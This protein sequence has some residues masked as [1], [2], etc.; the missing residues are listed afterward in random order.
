MRFS[1]SASGGTWSK[2]YYDP[3]GNQ[4]SPNFGSELFQFHSQQYDSESNL[5]YMRA[6]YYDPELGRFISRDPVKGNIIAPQSLHPY[7]YA[8]NNPINMSDTSGEIIPE[9][10][11]LASGLFLAGL[12]VGG[13]AGGAYNYYQSNCDRTL[14]GYGQSAV[15]GM[16]IAVESKPGQVALGA[17]FLSA[18]FV[19]P[20]TN[21][22]QKYHGND[23]RNPATTTGYS[24]QERSAGSIMKYGESIKP[25]TRY[26][27]LFCK[28]TT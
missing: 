12:E 21:A 5:Y 13:A 3:F 15:V 18:A 4:R 16:Q 11:F 28:R 23:L 25:D 6:R 7:V 24:L 14:S 26:P 8:A 27:D 22:P 19:T 17:A 20:E 10:I 9:L 1:T 2:L